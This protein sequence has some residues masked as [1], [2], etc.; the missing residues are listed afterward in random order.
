MGIVNPSGSASVSF[1]GRPLALMWRGNIADPSK[2]TNHAERFRPLIAELAALGIETRHVVYFDD[3]IEAARE[4]LLQSSGVLVWINPIQDGRDR[5]S[6]DRLL[7]DVA[8]QGV[9]VSALPDTIDRL[10]TKEVLYATRELGWGVDTDRYGSLDELNLRF[11]VKLSVA[12]ARVLKPSRGND[13]KGV[14]KVE[15]IAAD[16]RDVRVQAASDDGVETMSLAALAG[17][18]AP[19]FESGGCVIDQAFSPDI[20]AGMVRCYMSLDRVVG[21]SEQSPRIS[22][23][24]GAA[25]PFGMN[26]A[27]TMHGTEAAKFQELRRL[28]EQD[29]TP[30]LQRLLGLATDDLPALWDADFFHRTAPG[31]PPFALCEINV[32]SVSP[33]PDDAATAIAATVQRTLTKR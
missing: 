5:R 10:G 25:P 6:V 30:G 18:F 4:T 27:K 13:G 24:D 9:W 23:A 33:F 17:R 26:S 12:G 19:V 32:S 28:M 1:Q 21:F 22:R 31:L 15:R 11:P 8:V 20:G 29:W 14:L 7:R 2:P 16:P 3:A